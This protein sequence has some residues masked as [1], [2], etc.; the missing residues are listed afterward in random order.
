VANLLYLSRTR[1]RH[2]ERWL[3]TLREAGHHVESRTVSEA[4][5]A[6]QLREQLGGRVDAVVAGPLSDA[7]PL[8]VDADLA[9]V[10]AL[11]WAFDVLVELRDGIETAV[12]H[13]LPRCAGVHCDCEDLAERVV[14]LGA[15]RENVSMAAWGIDL[16]WFTPGA[17]ERD[18]RADQGWDAEQIVVLSTRAWEPLYGLEIALAGFA[19]A[20]Q[21]DP[22]LRLALAGSGSLAV[23]VHRQTEYLGLEPSVGFVGVLDG[24]G[25]RSWLRASDV[26]LSCARSDGSSLSLLEAL[27]CGLPAV[28]T[29]LA[30]NREWLPTGEVGR[31][32]RM[33]DDGDLA[34]VLGGV[35]DDLPWLRMAGQRRRA[36]VLERGDWNR[37]R[38]VF[39]D[40]LDTVLE[41]AR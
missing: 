5:S 40:A 34:A 17:P 9:P 21:R 11:C 4:G 38:R 39:L 22:R 14:G 2:D 1:G 33:D 37:N 27:A 25:L 31:V 19:K 18:V 30:G 35:A 16:D 41:R 7:V 3:R 28:V 29:D 26:Y 13:A 15:P 12:R 6:T 36:V 23:E 10:L 32:F 24:V 20:R 8:A